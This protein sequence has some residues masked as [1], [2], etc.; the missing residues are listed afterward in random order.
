MRLKDWL[1]SGLQY[2]AIVVGASFLYGTLMGPSSVGEMLTMTAMYMLLFGAAIN[3]LYNITV[4]KVMLPLALS[5][6]S[7]RKEAFVGIQCYRL[8]YAVLVIGVAVPLY[9][10]AREDGVTELMIFVPI[11]IGLMLMMNALGAVLGMIGNR[12]GKGVMAVLTVVGSL[13]ACGIV[14]TAVILFS[15]LSESIGSYYGLWLLP[16]VGLVIYGLVSI[17][18][19]KA[20][21]KYS[22]K[23]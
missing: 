3:M 1:K 6:G 18:E 2:G 8:V 15:F 12:F 20:V 7:T 22:V 17:A 21:K 9:L 5:F 11:G 23:L 4:Y 13:I 10:L 14:V 19:H 16:V